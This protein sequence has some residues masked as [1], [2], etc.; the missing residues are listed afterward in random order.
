MTGDLEMDGTLMHGL[1]VAYPP[2]IYMIRKS[3][4]YINWND[5]T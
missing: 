5:S 4:D 2:A 3:R 1:Q